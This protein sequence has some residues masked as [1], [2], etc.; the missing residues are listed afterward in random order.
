MLNDKK[1][2][3]T[4]EKENQNL[5]SKQLAEK[6]EEKNKLNSQLQISKK[7]IGIHIQQKTHFS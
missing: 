5:N 1:C 4:S 6:E 7:I 3:F 2:A